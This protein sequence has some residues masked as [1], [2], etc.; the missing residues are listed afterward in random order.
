MTTKWFN[1]VCF[2]TRIMTCQESLS[3]VTCHAV[4][5]LIHDWTPDFA[6]K[7]TCVTTWLTFFDKI[8]TLTLRGSHS[9]HRRTAFYPFKGILTL[10]N[11]FFLITTTNFTKLYM[12]WKQVLQLFTWLT[13]RYK[14]DLYK[15]LPSYTCYEN[16]FYPFK[17]ILTE[18]FHLRVKWDGR[19][20][21]L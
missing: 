3:Y 12:S 16:K 7:Q 21:L 9:K 4:A 14:K 2:V 8:F 20:L 1:P 6:P 19:E 10:R 13:F 5:I 15:L 18:Y 11:F 17:G